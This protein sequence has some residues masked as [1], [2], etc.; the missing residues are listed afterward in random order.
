ML[1]R[2][3]LAFRR[4]SSSHRESLAEQVE[5]AILVSQY[6][7]AVNQPL[8]RARGAPRVESRD[9]ADVV[10]CRR[11]E[12]EGRDDPA[13]RLI[14]EQTNELPRVEHEG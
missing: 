4:G 13:P 5:A 14:R 11:V 6:E 2:S 3:R 8:Q 7:P 9:L 1:D 10:E 12:D